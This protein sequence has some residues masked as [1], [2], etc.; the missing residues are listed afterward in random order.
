MEIDTAHFKGN[1]PES[2]E[3]HAV[4]RPDD[5][6]PTDVPAD[7]WT[8]ILPRTKLGPHRQHFFQLER[9]AVEGKSYTHVKITI[10]PDGGIKRAI[11]D[12]GAVGVDGD[13]FRG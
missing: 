11:V 9:H 7:E 6:V 5:L 1:F 4:N 10:Y 13:R 3:L 2:C 12:A 8:L